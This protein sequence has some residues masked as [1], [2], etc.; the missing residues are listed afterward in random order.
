MATTFALLIDGENISASLFDRIWKAARKRADD[1]AVRRVYGD[2]T[3]LNGWASVPGLRVVHAGQ[4]KNATDMLLCIEA[5]DLVHRGV[6]EGVILATSDRDFSHLALHLRER[7]VPAH[8]IVEEKAPETFR[9][10]FRSFEVLTTEPRVAPQTRQAPG[11]PPSLARP[12][13]PAAPAATPLD[14]EIQRLI[15]ENGG[16]VLMSKLNTSL[17]G[18][19]DFR[20]SQT[21]E[22]TWWAYLQARPQLYRCDPRGAEAQVR[23]A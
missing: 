20:I 19:K 16:R 6:V 4:G 22:K 15:T 3:R 18:M 1:L 11:L 17:R 5:L 7:G 10:T 23:L 21:P 8:G 12:V 2:A 13:A 14:V 9:Y